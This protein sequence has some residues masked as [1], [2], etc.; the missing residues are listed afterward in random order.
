M[1]HQILETIPNQTITKPARWWVSGLLGGLACPVLLTV[2]FLVIGRS[3]LFA[4]DTSEGFGHILLTIIPLSTLPMLLAFA[5]VA[6]MGNTRRLFLQVQYTGLLG[7]TIIGLTLVGVYV[8]VQGEVNLERT[9]GVWPVFPVFYVFSFVLGSI[10]WL[11]FRRFNK[12]RNQA[13]KD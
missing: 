7:A 8:Y 10:I 12:Y 13:L 4:T 6:M 3:G 1:T 11:I 9:L 2:L 5:W